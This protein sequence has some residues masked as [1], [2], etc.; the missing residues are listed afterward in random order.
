MPVAD[1]SKEIFLFRQWEIF[2]GHMVHKQKI[3]PNSNAATNPM[4]VGIL[5]FILINKKM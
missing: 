5:F 3:A 2:I 1:S 4:K